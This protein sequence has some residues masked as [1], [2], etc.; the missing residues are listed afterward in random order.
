MKLC[1]AWPDTPG[2][3]KVSEEM[4]GDTVNKLVF[5]KSVD[6]SIVDR[7]VDRAV[8]SSMSEILKD[9]FDRDEEDPTEAHVIKSTAK[10]TDEST[11]ESASR[12][13]G[14]TTGQ[15]SNAKHDDRLRAEKGTVGSELTIVW[16]I[17]ASMAIVFILALQNMWSRINSL[18]AWL[19][20]RLATGP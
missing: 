6:R 3:T 20:G 13:T 8:Q 19:H 4:S 1:K 14:R 17:M 11:A 9:A 16:A 18:E 5:P 10:S 12:S 15:V 7:A 2:C